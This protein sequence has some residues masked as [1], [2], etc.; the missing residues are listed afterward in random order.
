VTPC[1][2]CAS[3]SSDRPGGRHSGGGRLPGRLGG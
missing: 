1:G 2:P 3:L